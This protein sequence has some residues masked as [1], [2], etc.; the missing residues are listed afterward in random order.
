MKKIIISLCIPL[1]LT[2][3]SNVSASLIL[4]TL[5]GESA[6]YEDVSDTYWYPHL[7][8]LDHKTVLRQLSCPVGVN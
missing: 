3:A 4:N 2:L 8:R 5:G 6:I 7:Y 1:L